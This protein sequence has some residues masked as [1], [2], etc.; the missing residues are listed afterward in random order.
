MTEKDDAQ[1][2]LKK[3][4]VQPGETFSHYKGGGVYEVV[5]MAI[6]EGTLEPLVVYRSLAHASTWVRTYSNFIE[7]VLHN[8]S[9]VSRFQRLDKEFTKR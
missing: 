3:L 1:A 7:Q 6:D 9:L 2:R 5:T 8:G 4:P